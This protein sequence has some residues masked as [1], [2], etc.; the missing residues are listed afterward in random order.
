MDVFFTFIDK[1][2]KPILK[3]VANYLAVS[4]K[5]LKKVEKIKLNNFIKYNYNLE[6]DGFH[7]NISNFI[8]IVDNK[9][10]FLYRTV[11]PG[12]DKSVGEC[13]STNFFIAR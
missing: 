13:K 7:N 6:I 4:E 1:I 11:F 8:F 9:N 2:N 10:Y 12:S 5:E 3:V